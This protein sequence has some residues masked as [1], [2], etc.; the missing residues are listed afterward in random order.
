MVWWPTLLFIYVV[1][2]TDVYNK[3]ISCIEASQDNPLTELKCD[4][5]EDNVIQLASGDVYVFIYWSLPL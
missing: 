4:I 5:Q 2:E 1:G 3:I